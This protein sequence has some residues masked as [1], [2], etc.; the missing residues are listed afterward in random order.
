MDQYSQCFWKLRIL[1]LNCS[2]FGKVGKLG[3]Y[4][5]SPARKAT[6]CW[7]SR[8]SVR[9]AG[10]SGSVNAACVCGH[11]RALLDAIDR[12]RAIRTLQN[13]RRLHRTNV[14]SLFELFSDFKNRVLCGPKTRQVSGACHSVF[15]FDRNAIIGSIF[16][17]LRAGRYPASSATAPSRTTMPTKVNGS[18]GAVRNKREAIRR[19]TA[20]DATTPIEMPTNA[21]RMVL[22]ITSSCTRV[23]VAPRAMRTP[24][25]GLWRVTEYEITP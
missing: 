25:S 21:N 8:V 22:Q 13:R 10:P 16:E 12:L 24:I 20:N 6:G 14:W 1:S 5:Q 4:T 18:L 23:S 3:Q 2:L 17:A 7:P 15:Q 11:F 9:V 19:E